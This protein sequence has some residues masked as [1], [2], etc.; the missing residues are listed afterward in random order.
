M[1][2]KQTPTTKAE[3]DADPRY[4]GQPHETC[5]ECGDP[6]LPRGRDAPM[7]MHGCEHRQSGDLWPGEDREEF[8]YPESL[9]EESK[10]LREHF[11]PW[12]P[13]E[14]RPE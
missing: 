14:D 11:Y 13:E 9:V 5:E 6:V 3:F 4:N 12:A 8:G 2:T 7:G 1:T 10:Q